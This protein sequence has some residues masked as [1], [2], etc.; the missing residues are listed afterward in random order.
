[1]LNDKYQSLIPHI[2]DELLTDIDTLSSV[3]P[4]S[5]DELHRNK[6]KKALAAIEEQSDQ[7][8]DDEGHNDKPTYFKQSSSED[9]SSDYEDISG[10]PPT[11]D[12]KRKSH[13]MEKSHSKKELIQQRRRSSSMQFGVRRP[14][15]SNSLLV[16]QKAVHKFTRLY[17]KKHAVSSPLDPYNKDDQDIADVDEGDMEERKMP[18]ETNTLY[19]KTLISDLNIWNK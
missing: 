11:L 8:S 10:S 19:Q 6:S 18:N 4:Q 16:T 15:L 14:S 5:P 9:D 3:S 17:A 1:M 7:D 13:G 2:E 12:E